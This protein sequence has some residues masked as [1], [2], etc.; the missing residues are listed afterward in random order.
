MTLEVEGHRATDELRSLREWLLNEEELR[1]RV[2]LVDG[3]VAPGT[4]GSGV[5]ALAVI[6]APGGIAT[7]VASVL[8]A[9]IRH[10]TSDVTLK[11]TRPDGTSYELSATDVPDF[12]TT[13]VADLAAQL[14]ASVTSAPA[15]AAAPPQTGEDDTAG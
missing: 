4:L 10:R 12:S 5:E 8:I 6:L 7:A 14:S 1:G 3:P 9:W 2:R 13:A 11:V 15:I